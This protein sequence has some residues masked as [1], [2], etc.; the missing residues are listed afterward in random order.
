MSSQRR[1]GK[2]T[3]FQLFSLVFNTAIATG[4]FTIARSTGDVA[5][6]GF[7]AAILLAVLFSVL[8]LAGMYL[9][10][11][12]FPDQSLPEYAPVILGRPLAAV[13]LFGYFLI[14]ISL[15]VVVPRNYWLILSSWIFQRTPQW[16]FTVPLALV[17][18]NVARRGL[19]VLSRISEMMLVLSVPALI[20]LLIPHQSFDVDFLRPLLD[21]GPGDL[22][23][24]VLPAYFSMTG[25]DIL[26]FAYPFSGRRRAFRTA[27]LGVTV[28]GLVYTIS[29]MLI[30]GTL[31]L[32]LTLLNIWPLQQYLNHFNL[33]VVERLDVIFLILWTVQVC[34]TVMIPLFEAAA[35]LR[36]IFPALG[37]Q[38]ATNLALLVLLAG[39]LL[40]T[41]LPAQVQL[42]NAYSLAALFYIGLLP[43]FLWL[44]AK[45]R[46]KGGEPSAG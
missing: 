11:R 21:K 44:I 38:G 22:L 35:C 45:L 27:A 2:L 30:V 1:R 36:G 17:C 5:G 25:F 19:V 13:Y 6:R 33:N 43:P 34:M 32:E 8:Q 10:S 26:L 42:Q 28:V 18:W 29:S 3:N 41:R 40:P 15:A 23:K 31:G 20:L 16:A 7:W 37:T 24:G 4:V 9:L 12:Q 46:G 14:A 39:L